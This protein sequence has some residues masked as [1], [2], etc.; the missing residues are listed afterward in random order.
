[1]KKEEKIRIYIVM[2]KL[3]LTSLLITLNRYFSS[4]QQNLMDAR[5]F[6]SVGNYGS[7]AVWM[8][9]FFHMLKLG[10]MACI[11]LSTNHSGYSMLTVTAVAQ[12]GRLV[13]VI[14]FQ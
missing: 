2:N 6:S 11:R 4:A 10:V 14:K 7:A 5:V 13:T 3:L 1:M 9:N 8:R 12:S